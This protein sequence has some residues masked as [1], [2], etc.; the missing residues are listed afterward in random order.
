MDNATYDELSVTP[1]SSDETY[2]RLRMTHNKVRP[3]DDLTRKADINQNTA[4]GVKQINTKEVPRN[5][6]VTIAVLITT[7]MVLLI[8]MLV[9]IVLSVATF[10]RLTSE[11]SRLAKIENQNEDTRSE[12][13]QLIY[14]QNNIS[15]TLVQL[16]DQLNDFISIEFNLPQCGAGLWWRVAYLNMTEPSQ[17]CPSAWRE[18][19]TSGVRACGR[20]VSSAGSCAAEFYFTN[21]QY[22][23][24]CGRIIG[25]QVASPDAFTRLTDFYGRGLD[26]VIISHGSQQDHIWSYAAG[27]TEESSE[28]SESHCPCSTEA[29][30]QPPSS[31]GDCYCE[32][33]N[34]T[35]G[36]ERGQL[37]SSDRLWDGQQCESEGSC[38]GGTQSPPW[39]SVQLHAP[40]TDTIEVSICCDQGT[41]DEDTPV[42]L[43]EMYVQ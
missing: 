37:Y 2:S 17:Q 21:R 29:V 5:T 31:I 3:S 1:I 40:T 43:I 35:D 26:G 15:Q 9:S 25:Y 32:S 27:L 34:P 18:Y 24:V 14:M 13:I 42:E 20:P 36:F 41:M 12:L 23:R 28:T 16:N 7:I 22:S 19:N 10:S 6:K 38:C 39:F 30:T 33:G 11:Q 8:L 4:K